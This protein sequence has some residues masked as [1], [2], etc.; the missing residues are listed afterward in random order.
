GNRN[1]YVKVEG[2]NPSH[3]VKCRIG[4]NMIWDAEKSGKLKPGMTII[5]PTSGNTGIALAYV[6]AARR[7]KLILT[8]P[9]S[10][11]LGR[12][13]GMEALGAE[14]GLADPAK[15][16]KGAVAKAEA[17]LGGN[18]DESFMPQQFEDPANP[19]THDPTTGPEIWNATA[20]AV[21]IFVSGAAT[22]GTL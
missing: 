14:I 22:G 13:V 4:A 5:E 1:I 19:E 17:R 18:P 21:D 8:M 7:Y 3:S 11:S 6:A 2:R 10:M 20:G 16:I 9:S 12:R 15:G